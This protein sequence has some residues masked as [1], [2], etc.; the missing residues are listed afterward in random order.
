MGLSP[1]RAGV[2][3]TGQESRL[4]VR[5]VLRLRWL[6]DGLGGRTDNGAAE[7]GRAACRQARGME[8][9]AAQVIITPGGTLEPGAPRF[10]TRPF[11]FRMAGTNLTL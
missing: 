3:P 1:R 11:P 7:A 8:R 4:R 2:G 6:A 9:R 10:R 5:A